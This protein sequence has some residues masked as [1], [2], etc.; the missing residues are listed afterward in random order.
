MLDGSQATMTG[1]FR[2]ILQNEGP[3]GLYHGLTPNFLKVAPAVSISYVVYEHVRKFLGVDMTWS[4]DSC[5]ACFPRTFFPRLFCPIF[6]VHSCSNIYC[7]RTHLQCITTLSGWICI[8]PKKDTKM[9]F[10]VISPIKLRRF[11]QNAVHS[12]LKKFAAKLCNRF[13][14]H[15]NNVSTLPCVTWNAHRARAAVD[16]QRK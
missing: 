15:L 6:C 14:P 10:F 13:P 2:T 3:T 12:F 8:V 11:W 7:D 1:L 9:F 5:R 16:R 4:L